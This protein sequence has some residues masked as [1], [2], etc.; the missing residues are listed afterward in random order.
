MRNFPKLG[1][2]LIVSCLVFLA[3]AAVAQETSTRTVNFE[4]VSVNGNTIVWKDPAGVTKEFN[5]PAGFKVNMDGKELGVAELKPGMKGSA[6][7]TT[8]TT[9]KPVVVSEV[10]NA[11]VL[12]VSGNAIVV[13][14]DGKP[15]KYTEADV[16][17]RKAKLYR[18]GVE[19]SLGQ[20]RPGDRLSATIVTDGPPEVVTESQVAAMVNPG[21]SRLRSGSRSGSRAGS[22]CPLRRRNPGG[23]GGNPPEDGQ[24]DAAHRPRRLAVSRGGIRPAVDPPVARSPVKP[25][26]SRLRRVRPSPGGRGFSLPAAL[27][28]LLFSSGGCPRLLLDGNADFGVVEGELDPHHRRLVDLDAGKSDD[29]ITAQLR[30]AGK[31][32]GVGV[33]QGRIGAD[34]GRDGVG[35]AADHLVSD[36]ASRRERGGDAQGSVEAQTFRRRDPR[37][38]VPDPQEHV[39]LR[40]AAPAGPRGELLPETLA[41]VLVGSD[42]SQ[43]RH[44]DRPE[45]DDPGRGELVWRLDQAD[46][47]APARSPSKDP[48]CRYWRGATPNRRRNAREN[49][50]WLWKPESRAT[51]RMLPRWRSRRIAARSSRRRC[52]YCLTVSPVSRVNSRS[53]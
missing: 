41:D 40:H 47:R 36:S 38:V 25:N 8:T 7:I 28:P 6:V 20:F 46:P 53:K 15:R 19:V 32:P 27:H 18:N 45:L 37:S 9:M 34:V 24:P 14:Q 11:E 12:A 26:R 30:Q 2:L 35:S 10:K 5:A 39:R 17:R 42:V 49:V 16:T 48:R 50:S 52:V 1:P 43:E 51:S 22:G 31:H 13:R 44:V 23:S 33:R 29:A 3:G 4:I 21:P